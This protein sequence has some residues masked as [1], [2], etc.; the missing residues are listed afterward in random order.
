M[1]IVDRSQPST[2]MTRRHFISIPSADI[3]QGTQQNMHISAPHTKKWAAFAWMW[4]V[5]YSSP[6]FLPHMDSTPEK[7]FP[8]S[9]IC[10]G[11]AFDNLSLCFVNYDR[12]IK[13]LYKT[14]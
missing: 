13:Y 2:G 1:I 9:Q 11:L 4:Y 14:I 7:S 5:L 6:T 10:P 12:E 8:S 3:R